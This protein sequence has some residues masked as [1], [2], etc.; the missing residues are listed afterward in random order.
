M[1]GLILHVGHPKTG[2]TALQSVLAANSAHGLMRFSILYPLPQSPISHKH[3]LSIPWLLS[4]DNDAIRKSSCASGQ[5]LQ[6]L[7]HD[8]WKSIVDICQRNQVATVILSAEGFWK[9]HLIS[10]WIRER[11]RRELLTI[12]D[13]ITIVGYLRS[14]ASYLLSMINQKMRNFKAFV[15]PPSDYLRSPM[16][17]WEAGGFDHCSWRRFDHE[18][19][20]NSYQHLLHPS[21]TK[22]LNWA[23]VLIRAPALIALSLMA[24]ETRSPCLII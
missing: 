2:T 21:G 17:A 8:Y 19:L 6:R 14:P 20:I 5:E 7:S 3:A 16:Q 23:F 22:N 18:T 12:A 4:H 1:T 15:V 24:C 11:F 10:P 9:L 13:R